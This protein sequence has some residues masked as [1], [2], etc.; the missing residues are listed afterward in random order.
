MIS[1]K[2]SHDA[3]VLT[4]VLLAVTILAIPVVLYIL[5]AIWPESLVRQVAATVCVL[6][7]VAFTLFRNKYET[8]LIAVVF[9][10]QFS[11]SLHSFTLD[12]PVLL[13]IF[14]SDLI[15]G[16]LILVAFERQLKVRLDTM[17]WLF[18]MWIGWLVVVSYFSTHLHRSIIFA[19]WQIKYFVLYALAL[20]ITML[21][22]F[23]RRIEKTI[24]AVILIQ[25]AIGIAQL[26]HGGGLGLDILGESFNTAKMSEYI[27]KG[28]LRIGGTIGATNA[29]AGYMAM[30]LVFLLPFVVIRRSLLS[31]LGFGMG[32]IALIFSIQSRMAEFCGGQLM[33][34]AHDVA[35]AYVEAIKYNVVRLVRM[36][37]SVWRSHILRR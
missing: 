21:V 35:R 32:I 5:F 11:V 25:T 14:L 20:N 27:V 10:S 28:A 2:R 16:L 12:P 37:C 17:G 1:T 30:L 34:N 31:Y 6:L 7:V 9:L 29:F 18:I 19:V 3:P 26:L 15:I 22:S 4:L 13:Q 36:S 24:L 8:L 33:R 23:I